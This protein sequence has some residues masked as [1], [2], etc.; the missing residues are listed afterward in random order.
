MTDQVDAMFPNQGMRNNAKFI[1]A[2]HPRAIEYLEQAPVLA[3]AFGAKASTRADRLYTASRIGG[4]IERGERLR[5][6][7]STVGMA[8][9][10][11]KLKASI[12][13]PTARDHIR[14]L[15][16]V[17]NSAL[18]QSIPDSPGQQRKWLQVLVQHRIRCNIR[19]HIPTQDE[20]RW[21]VQHGGRAFDAREAGDIV[22]YIAN[23]GPLN[24]QRWDWSR[25]LAEVELW[26]D[27]LAAESAVGKLFGGIS[28]DTRID[29]SDWPDHAEIG[30]FEIF[31]LTTPAMLMEEGRRMRHCVSSYIGD[32]ING[33]CTILSIRL[34]MRRIATAQIVGRKCVQLKG[35]ANRRAPHG[36]ER[37][38]AKFLNPKDP[39]P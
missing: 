18:S 17:G 11:R 6:V 5:N 38:V 3:L 16:W 26:H 23:V 27:R 32:V 2:L 19:D 7:M 30:A 15:D 22:D 10:L 31:K 36:V 29:L 35:F 20:L 25:A 9:P 13:Y 24:W 4:P 21:F 1:A 28:A 8:Y 14:S 33:R 34:E 37:A 12:L 39:T